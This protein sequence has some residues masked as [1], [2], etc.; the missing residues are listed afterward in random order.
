[1][2]KMICCVLLFTSVRAIAQYPT[3]HMQSLKE[4]GAQPLQCMMQDSSG[5]MWF[6]GKGQLLRY[7]GFQFQAVLLPE[8]FKNIGI[9]ALIQANGCIWAGFD[10]GLIG[11]LPAHA[12]FIPQKPN[13]NSDLPQ[14]D[15][16]FKLWTPEEGL[17]GKKITAFAADPNGGLWFSSYGEGLYCAVKGHIYQWNQED[18][19]L[20]NDEI[21]T[22][23]A[24][25]LGRIWVATDAGISICRMSDDGKKQISSLNTQ[26]SS[27]PDNL[28]T[29]LMPDGFG[30]MLIGTFEHGVL[31]YHISNHFLENCTPNWNFGAVNQILTY[32]TD[33]IWVNTTGVGLAHI[34]TH[35]GTHFAVPAGKSAPYSRYAKVFKDREGLLWTLSEQGRPATAN[36][37]FGFLPLPYRDIQAVCVDVQN[38]VWIGTK[39]GA[40]RYA[41]HTLTT[42]LPE[43][44]NILS[45]WQAPD[46]SIWCGSFGN[47]VYQFSADGQ[48]LYHLNEKNGLL[49][50]SVLS[51]SG[52]SNLIWL[53][54]LGGV[55]ALESE[56]PGK[57]AK[58]KEHPELG[59]CYVYKI[60][61]DQT[62]GFWFCTDG[63][64]LLYWKNGKVQS[65]LSAGTTPIKTIYSISQD[66]KNKIWF[67]TEKGNL[68]CYDGQKFEKPVD[69]SA[70]HSPN[71]AG[72]ATCPDNELVLA[73]EDGLEI[74]NIDRNA[75]LRFYDAAL[76]A[77]LRETSLNAICTDTRGNIW[78]GS[79]GGLLRI[80]GY[81]A[82]YLEDP[83]PVISSVS[84]FDH[85]FDFYQ[86]STF[87]YD[88]NYFSFH[89]AG[90]WYTNPES[91][92]Y[93]YK[94]EGFDPEWK[95]SKDRIATY[96]KLPP[97]N[98]TFRV[99]AS[100][101]GNFDGV[102]VASWQFTI[103]QPFWKRWWFVLSALLLGAILLYTLIRLRENRLKKAESLKKA[104]VESQFSALKSQ[105]NPHFLFNSFNTLITIIEENPHTAVAYVEHLSD[106]YRSIMVYRE[107]DLIP[108][109]EEMTLVRNFGFLLKNRYGDNFSLK[110]PEYH[111]NGQIMPLTLQMLV[112]N[113]VKHN[114]ISA[115][116]PLH[117]EIFLEKPGYITVRNNLQMKIKP[118]PGAQFGLRSLVERYALLGER[119]VLILKNNAWFSVEVPI[120]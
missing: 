55:V 67:T 95:T 2:K 70:L 80:A 99:Q 42:I 6:G 34:D 68:F 81:K 114:I 63:K 38:Q 23:C 103:S 18:D 88:E 30:N 28:V 62:E 53:A 10:N 93:R 117:V 77:P 40:Y 75:H 50:G 113:A 33:D 32:G 106:F 97:G 31:R 64:G 41:N 83:I 100:E 14:F 11:Y 90:L 39:N 17:P 109:Q 15:A 54:T 119:P 71:I 19:G 108:L 72:L 4:Y 51:I 36:M 44:E 96:P 61:A 65:F 49:N 27:M 48:K 86:K 35:A 101:H 57:A 66:N 94:L 13:F 12:L 37:R 118:E 56:S 1:M 87:H 7:D 5:W 84:V 73:Y 69:A 52:N 46:G 16:G 79:E 47:G 8:P 85:F 59:S 111:G 58:I 9:T 102:P 3:F 116:K 74:F 91:V 112:E 78:I 76:G 29:A 60:W 26:N 45:I 82:G 92:L 104:M 21:Y 105:I 24:D 25:P 115:A 107:R 110:M 120:V 22:I 20:A 98:Y 89:F 43:S